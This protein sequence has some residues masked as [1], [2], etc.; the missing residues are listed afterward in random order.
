MRSH[1]RGNLLFLIARLHQRNINVNRNVKI[2]QMSALAKSL[3]DAKVSVMNHSKLLPEG[4]AEHED[5]AHWGREFA[6]RLVNVLCNISLDLWGTE[7]SQ[8]AY[9]TI[10][11]LLKA[12]PDKEI[13]DL[14]CN[15]QEMLDGRGDRS[16]LVWAKV[17]L[18]PETTRKAQEEEAE[19]AHVEKERRETADHEAREVEEHRQ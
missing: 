3:G 6:K 13:K 18:M 9:E 16:W 8:M 12:E 15:A 1:G 17:R 19:A 10:A 2:H 14:V 11:R 7:W 4:A 5:Y